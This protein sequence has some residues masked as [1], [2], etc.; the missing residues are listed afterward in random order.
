M[1]ILSVLRVFI[2]LF[3][4][5]GLIHR[6]TPFSLSLVR[7]LDFSSHWRWID[8]YENLPAKM[9]QNDGIAV[10]RARLVDNAELSRRKKAN[11]IHRHF[12]GR[13]TWMLCT[14]NPYSSFQTNTRHCVCH[15]WL[16]EFSRKKKFR[17]SRLGFRKGLNHLRWNDRRVSS[18]VNRCSLEKF[19]VQV[20]AGD[21]NLPK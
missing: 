20:R 6:S 9:N 13:S 16:T 18:P 2:C 19:R 12:Q 14:P 5:L 3:S 11:A 15:C 21:F 7:C 4:S 10:K 17:A 1:P 8:L